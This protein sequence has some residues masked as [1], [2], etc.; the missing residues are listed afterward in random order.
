VKKVFI[1]PKIE[2]RILGLPACNLVTVR[3]VT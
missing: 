3:P 1:L 2:P